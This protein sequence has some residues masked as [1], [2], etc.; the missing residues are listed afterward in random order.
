MSRQIDLEPHRKTN[1]ILVAMIITVA[2]MCFCAHANGEEPMPLEFS[3]N[4]NAITD[5]AVEHRAC[6]VFFKSLKQH[7]LLVPR[8][9]DAP[10]HGF[11]WYMMASGFNQ[12]S[13]EQD[14]Q[15]IVSFTMLLCIAPLQ[16]VCLSVWHQGIA[17]TPHDLAKDM[18]TQVNHSLSIYASWRD[19][20]APVFNNLCPPCNSR[21][22]R[23]A[24]YAQ[25]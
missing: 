22:P 23:E 18:S 1:I 4:C 20:A 3:L 13:M 9:P 17:T 21:P 8:D 24:R 6:G 7:E 15:I 2:I 25:P 14:K 19:L 12:G 16:G 11:L 10:T 5:H